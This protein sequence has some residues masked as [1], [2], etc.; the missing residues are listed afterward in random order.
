MR[1][2][3][4]YSEFCCTSRHPVVVDVQR[5]GEGSDVCN[6]GTRANDRLELSHQMADV[7]QFEILIEFP[8]IVLFWRSLERPVVRRRHPLL[9]IEIGKSTDDR[10]RALRTPLG[11]LLDTG[12]KAEPQIM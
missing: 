1:G 3:D 12:R 5:Q 8:V 6:M 7:M 11:D 9:A 10:R 2:L 4:R